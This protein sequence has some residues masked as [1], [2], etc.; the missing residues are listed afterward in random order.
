MYKLHRTDSITL[1]HFC[2]N[3]K[4]SIWRFDMCKNRSENFCPR[5]YAKNALYPC[6]HIENQHLRNLT[7][8]LIRLEYYDCWCSGSFRRQVTSGHG[9]GNVELTHSCMRV[10][11][12]YLRRLV[13]R[14][15]RKWKEFL[16]LGRISKNNCVHIIYH[17]SLATDLVQSLT[18]PYMI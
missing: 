12:H 5:V 7:I 15:D 8:L 2:S 17:L 10:D 16:C 18:A 9:T 4:T 1:C 14:N 6:I 13:L 3:P 11:F